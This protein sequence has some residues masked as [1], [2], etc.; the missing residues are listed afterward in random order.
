MN[1]RIIRIA[2]IVVDL[3][4]GLSAVVGCVGLVTGGIQIPLS[5]LRGTPFTSYTVPGLILG[6][7]V[8][9]SALAAAAAALLKRRALDALTS[10]AAG[11]IMVGW[12]TV[13][14]AL[15]GLGTWAQPFYFAVGLVMIGLA[16]L[17]W[18]AEARDTAERPT[19]MQRRPA[20]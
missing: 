10:L 1:Q 11:G 9:G 18:V 19:P 3:F 16:V 13:E 8:G 4:A 17:L 6:I 7:V 12:I 20:A 14:V 15:I 5:L 2:L